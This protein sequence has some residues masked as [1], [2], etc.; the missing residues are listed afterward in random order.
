MRSL[1]N[2]GKKAFIP[3]I[4]AGYPD[5]EKTIELV[6]TLERSGADIIELG[7]PFSDPLAD[8]PTIQYSS[9]E[10]V[11]NGITVK[12]VFNSIKKIRIISDI[13]IIVFAYTNLILNYGVNRFMKDLKS[14]GGDG[15]LVPDLP[16]EE[17]EE[18]KTA[19][20]I[21]N[22][23]TIF[24]ITPLTEPERIKKIEK[25]SDDFVYCVS[26]TGVTGARKNIFS[27]IENYLTKNRKIM[28]KPFMVGFGVSSK[29]DARK[30]AKL[31]DGVVVGSALINLIN[32]YSDKKLL[33]E[34]YKFGSE[35]N[36]VLK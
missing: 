5:I 19:A 6:L 31:S 3:F 12:D 27:K 25:Y 16:I 28:T 34:T 23:R 22:I 15:V 20:K 33:Y 36:S 26:V 21:N 4:T 10:A 7:I 8:G 32:K 17:S 11:K 29:S 18:I 30:I 35:I 1:K 14:L 9:Y 13:P 2:S 24:L